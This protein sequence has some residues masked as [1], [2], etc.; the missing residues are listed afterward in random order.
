MSTH[1]IL[2]PLALGGDGDGNS[3]GCE[4]F[5]SLSVSDKALIINKTKEAPKIWK[6]KLEGMAL[7]VLSVIV[8]SAALTLALLINIIVGDPQVSSVVII[9]FF[10]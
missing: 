6:W 10:R 9:L 7:V 2:E 5:A 1:T 3:D 4:D 8:L